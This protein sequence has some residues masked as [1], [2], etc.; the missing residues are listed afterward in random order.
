MN[1]KSRIKVIHK[2]KAIEMNT[3]FTKMIENPFSEEYVESEKKSHFQK[4]MKICRILYHIKE[5]LRFTE[6]LPSLIFL[7]LKMQ[8]GRLLHGI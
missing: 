6:N 7:A 4:E 3:V 5:L 2:D 1:T 8:T